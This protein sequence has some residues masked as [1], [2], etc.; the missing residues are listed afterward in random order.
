MTLPPTPAGF[1]TINPFIITRDVD[2]LIGFLTDVFDGVDHPQ[3]RT[4][5]D[6]GLLLHAELQVGG[7]T[8]MFGERKPGW[9]FT[10]SLLQVYV[11]DVEATLKRAEERGAEVITRP[12]DFYGDV[13]SRFLDPWRNL[14]WV[15]STPAPSADADPAEGAAEA[16]WDAGEDGDWEGEDWQPTPE[17]TYIHDTLL[18]VL[19]RLQDPHS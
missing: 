9:P 14:W 3:A 16:S 17:L 6:D 10:P 2:G 15:Y 8:I 18:G 5:D 11:E 19:P 4:M 13:F 1:S 7:T 12:T